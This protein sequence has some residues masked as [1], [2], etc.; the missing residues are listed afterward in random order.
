QANNYAGGSYGIMGGF[1]TLPNPVPASMMEYDFVARN[2]QGGFDGQAGSLPS[3]IAANSTQTYTFPAYTVPAGYNT[4]NMRVIIMLIDHNGAP[5][6]Y[7]IMNSA[8]APVWGG[9]VTVSDPSATASVNVYPNPFDAG[10]NVNINLKASE[11]VTIEVYD[12]AGQLVSAQYAGQL[13][14]GQH[15][16]AL[17]GENLANGFYFVKVRAGQSTSTTKISVMH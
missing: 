7:R 1:E 3:T 12:M 4:N 11:E 10:T 8:S 13:A 16:I 5:S 9:A 15:N 6:D 17:S 14:I 2:L